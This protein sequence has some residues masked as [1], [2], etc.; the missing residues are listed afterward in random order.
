MN[1]MVPKPLKKQIYK[2]ILLK[3]TKDDINTHDIISE[4]ELDSLNASDI[5]RKIKRVKKLMNSA[6]IAMNFIDAAK[7][8]DNMFTLQKRLKEIR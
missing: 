6:A 1:N 5:K 3:T 8:R 7:H 2:H 4:K